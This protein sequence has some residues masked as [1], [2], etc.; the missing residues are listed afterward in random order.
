MDSAVRLVRSCLKGGILEDL[1][2][3]FWRS[4]AELAAQLSIP[5]IRGREDTAYY[6]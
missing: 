4:A 1:K 3:F 2:E 5:L 6:I